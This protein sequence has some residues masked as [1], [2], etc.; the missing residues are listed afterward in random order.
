MTTVRRLSPS[1]DMTF[2]Q[3]LANFAVD[4]EACLQNIRT[5]LYLVAGEWFLDL[6]AG[7]PYRE[8]VFVDPVQQALAEAAI[9][10]TILQTTDVAEI[11]TFAATLDHRTRVL[12]IA[13][14]VLTVYDETVS[15]TV[16]L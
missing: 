2:G 1:G 12:S 14:T 13:A 5:R 11:V 15:L 7:T 8:E 10:R 6:D 9:K 3:G 16:T 4:V